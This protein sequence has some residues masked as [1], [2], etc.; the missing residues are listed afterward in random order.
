MRWQVPPT[1]CTARVT[2]VRVI[3]T[4]FWKVHTF[5][6]RKTF[7]RLSTSW[8]AAALLGTAAFTAHAAEPI[9]IGVPIPM[10][11]PNTQ[12]GDEVKAGLLTAVETFNAAGGMNGRE[13]KP[14]FI[15]DACEPKQAVPAANTRIETMI[16]PN[17]RSHAVEAMRVTAK[18]LGQPRHRTLRTE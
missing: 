1:M 5:M 12:Y 4:L 2:S 3:H 10:T 8:A 7:I 15:D 16:A 11:G 9:L 17:P 14:V 13:Y 18:C 6:Q